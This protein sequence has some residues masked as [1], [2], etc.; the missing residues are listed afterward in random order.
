MKRVIFTA[1]VLIF[2]CSCRK[3]IR[4]A[5]PDVYLP[6]VLAHLRDSLGSGYNTLD[7]DRIFTG[8]PRLLRIGYRGKPIASDFL[9]VRTDSMGNVLR[10]QVVHLSLDGLSG[11]VETRSFSGKVVMS[12]GID[13]GVIT[14]LHVQ[15]GVSRTIV[16]G[17][18]VTTLPAPDADWLPEVVVV[19]YGGGSAGT[20]Y[21]A[22]DGLMGVSSGSII[23]SGGSGSS[24]SSGSSDG[25]GGASGSAGGGAPGTGGGAPGSGGSGSGSGGTTTYSPVQ[26]V[27]APIGRLGVRAGGEIE[28]EGEYIYSI[29]TVDVRKLFKCFDL[30]PDEGATYSVQLCVD[31]PV[32]SEPNMSMNFSGAINAGHT[33]LVVA[34]SGSGLSVSQS[35]GYYPQTAPSAWNPFSPIPS[36]IKDNKGQEINASI[37]MLINSEQFKAIGSAAINLSAQPYMLDKSNCTNYA[38][39]VFNAARTIPLAVE[40]YILVQSGIAIGNG[41]SSAPITATIN[42]SPQKLY[43]KLSTMKTNGDPEATNIQMDLS[44]NTKA[45]ISHGE[46]N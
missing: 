16:E 7:T 1:V 15:H 13:R 36:A 32:N 46:C 37:I 30:V 18:T 25:G 11:S 31:L 21:M 10:G 41:M 45:P 40:P 39:N 43:E 38:L 17:K 27:F 22:F 12:S 2:V 34:K 8:G 6:S 35:F 5:A 20:P 19:G 3:E 33:F 29:P 44:H 24:G 4:V 26:P 28:V 9:L 14:G 23:G 42:N